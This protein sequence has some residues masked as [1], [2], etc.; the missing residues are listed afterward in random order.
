MELNQVKCDVNDG[1]ASMPERERLLL[2]LKSIFFS[3]TFAKVDV[4]LLHM[5]GAFPYRINF[6]TSSALDWFYMLLKEHL[7]CVFNPHMIENFGRVRVSISVCC[8][9]A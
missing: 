3:H 9:F 1:R 6:V 4:A 5:S 8:F 2:I 7:F